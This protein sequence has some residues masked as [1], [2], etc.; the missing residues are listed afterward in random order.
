[1]ILEITKRWSS[2]KGYDNDEGLEM[3]Y[4]KEMK[5]KEVE[6]SKLVYGV[7]TEAFNILRV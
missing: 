7:K 6:A 5:K 1:M 4:L 2:F 3:R